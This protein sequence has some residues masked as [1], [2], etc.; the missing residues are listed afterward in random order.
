MFDFMRQNLA[1]YNT[2]LSLLSFKYRGKSGHPNRQA[3]RG[4]GVKEYKALQ[5]TIIFYPIDEWCIKPSFERIGKTVFFYWFMFVI[6]L[7]Y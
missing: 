4:G 3:N 2:S 1:R 6:V 5:I 7:E